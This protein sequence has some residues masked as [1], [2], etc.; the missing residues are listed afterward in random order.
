G[1]AP[2]I[3]SQPQSVSRYVGDTVMFSVTVDPNTT[4]P[5]SYQWQKNGTNIAAGTNSPLVLTNVQFADAGAYRV[6]VSNVV[7][8]AQS[9][10]AMLQLSTF[11][12]TNAVAYWKLDETNGLSAADSSG[13]GNAGTLTG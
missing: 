7:G 3:L 4:L 5:L 13:N 6:Q 1:I 2:A 8:V 10:N 9:S 11:D 12:L